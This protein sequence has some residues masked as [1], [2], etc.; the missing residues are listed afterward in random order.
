MC[1]VLVMS[2]IAANADVDK[3]DQP[4]VEAVRQGQIDEARRLLESGADVSIRDSGGT[5]PLS[6][7]VL[8]NNVEMARLLLEAGANVDSGGMLTP[9]ESALIG[10]GN[11]A[12]EGEMVRLLLD[13]GAD[14]HADTVML[15]WLA[16]GNQGAAPVLRL[17]LEAGADVDARGSFGRTA[18]H[19]TVRYREVESARRLLS[20]GASVDAP[21]DRGETPLF[22]AKCDDI[23][24]VRLLLEAGANSNIQNRFGQ[25]TLHQ[26]LDVCS[27]A[28]QVVRLLLEAGA[29]VNIQDR[30]GTTALHLA[31][32]D[33][34][35]ELTRML[36]EAGADVDARDEDGERPLHVAAA[37]GNAEMASFLIE[38]GAD[39]NARNQ[40]GE[41]PLHIAGY[42][43]SAEVVSLLIGAG[44]TEV[45]DRLY[46]SAG[47]TPEEIRQRR[48]AEGRRFEL[49]NACQQL[50]YGV[51]FSLPDDKSLPAGLT[52]KAISD[53]VESRMRAARL[54]DSDA[55]S[56]LFVYIN[57]FESS[58]GDR[59]VGWVYAT[60]VRFRKR[61]TDEASRIR[62]WAS[63]WEGGSFGTA[64]DSELEGA[65][66]GNVRGYMDEFLT[67]YL[68]VNEKACE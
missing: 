21:D 67:E 61:V 3:S 16:A 25:T 48:E 23:E 54:Y 6:A 45:P 15:L 40:D 32:S 27:E 64:P 33:G 44:A 53:A 18:L 51:G 57:L 50:D 58:V 28:E 38:A 63:T 12:S 68:R 37:L 47:F 19:E 62:R 22:W 29:D 41:T 7:A 59:H 49:F 11:A 65:I 8:D 35:I 5:T 34:N 39:L 20:V 30:R 1:A 10:G 56:S 4:L 66:L 36:V 24:A 60:N 2:A 13:A 17:L 31:A 26:V 55:S 42:S 43:D 14:V 9:L 46:E 52:E